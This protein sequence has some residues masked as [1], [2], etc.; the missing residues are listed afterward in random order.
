MVDAETN[1]EILTPSQKWCEMN[2]CL[3]YIRH[4]IDISMENDADF[5][6]PKIHLMS[7]LAELIRQYG[8]S[9]QYSAERHEHAH[10]TNLKNGWNASNHNLNYLVQVITIRCRIFCVEFQR[11]QSPR[12]RSA[13]GEH[14][15][16]QESLPFQC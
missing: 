12:P 9:Q 13:L 7:H 1:A 6:L 14:C 10:K 5:N 16:C 3:D 8:A 2:V 11:A 4:E 15:C